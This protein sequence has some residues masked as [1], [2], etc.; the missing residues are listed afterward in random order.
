M[1]LGGGPAGPVPAGR[2]RPDAPP[3]AVPVTPA[4]TWGVRALPAAE[5]QPGY[6]DLLGQC[7]ASAR[8]IVAADAGYA[9]VADEDGNLTVRGTAGIS[10]A[11]LLRS[12]PSVA[13]VPFMV[14]GRVTGVLAVA[15][16]LPGRFSDSDVQRLQ[17]LADSMAPVLERSRLA[18]LEQARRAR[19]AVLAEASDLLSGPLDADVV[20][21]TAGQVV[22]P[23]LA[24]WCALL[25]AGPGGD[26]RVA[27][28][29]HA[30]DAARE[31][32]TWLLERGGTVP[33]PSRPLPGWR[34]VALAAEQARPGRRAVRRGG[35][36]RPGRL[37]LPAGRRA[38]PLGLLVLGGPHAGRPSREVLSLA[39]DLAGRVALAVENCR[40][41]AQQQAERQALRAA[42]VPAELPR[43]PGFELAAAHD[44]P[45]TGEAAGG[46]FCDVFGV[47]DGR[48]RFAIGEVCGAGAATLAVT[49]LARA[50]LRILG[51]QGVSIPDTLSRLQPAHPG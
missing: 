20:M 1:G 21:A 16:M 47:A 12:A 41:A 34:S 31:A 32:L 30:D 39:Q 33:W 7:V 51:G 49:S 11:A 36:G 23:R 28:A 50:T 22:V 44:L 6:D 4:T 43:V 26:L 14:D 17:Q 24:E 18:E 2:P 3:G 35:T 45:G 5:A 29:R 48:W 9:L 38:G 40:L 46:D 13:T 10:P 19:I 25:I 42:L 37:V 27:A 8:V 15:A